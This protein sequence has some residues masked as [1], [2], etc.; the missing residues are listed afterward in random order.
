VTDILEQRISHLNTTDPV[1]DFFLLVKQKDFSQAPLID[2]GQYV[3]MITLA[4]VAR[5]VA[6]SQQFDGFDLAGT[7]IGTVRDGRQQQ[8]D[9]FI[10]CPP[11]T[12]V[13]EA[14]NRFDI[15]NNPPAR[16][17]VIVERGEIDRVCA[18]VTYE[19]LPLLLA[20]AH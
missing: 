18:L 10:E 13:P 19:D 16:G 7:L 11:S 6:E 2:D 14:L 1:R 17:L 20:H 9:V 4:T 5:W 15:D 3:G 12:T 8:E